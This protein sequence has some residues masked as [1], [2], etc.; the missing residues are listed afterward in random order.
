MPQSR[1]SSYLTTATLLVTAPVLASTPRS[2]PVVCTTKTE[3]AGV[4]EEFGERAMLTM[5]SHRNI[6]GT[7]AE[8]ATVL[9]VNPETKSWT[10]VERPDADTYCAIAH[11]ININPYDK[12]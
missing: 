1:L 4:L 5:I 12:P 6:T 10:L 8:I 7:T 2:V 9:F 3:M 11:G